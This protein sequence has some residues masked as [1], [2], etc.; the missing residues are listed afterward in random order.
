VATAKDLLIQLL[1][2]IQEVEKLKLKP[3]FTVPDD[4]FRAYARDI[5]DLE[6]I[7]FNL[8]Q[9]SDDIWMQ[10]PRLIERTPPTPPTS[11]APWV[12]LSKSPSTEPE[13]LREIDEPSGANRQPARQ[14]GNLESNIRSVRSGHRQRRC[15]RNRTAHYA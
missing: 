10:V 6:G 1:T 5:A 9:G 14:R 11:L 4:F 3:A 8:Q 2:Y 13:L 15:R 12:K 7:R